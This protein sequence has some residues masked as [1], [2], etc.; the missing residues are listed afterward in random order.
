MGWPTEKMIDYA[1]D[2][3]EKCGYDQDDYDFDNMTF[4]E[5]SDLIDDLK[6]ELGWD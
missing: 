2:L 4:E 1:K 3:I 5:C 6:I